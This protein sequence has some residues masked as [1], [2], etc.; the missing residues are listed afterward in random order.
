MSGP[1]LKPC[2][3][4]GGTLDPVDFGAQ[5]PGD[6]CVLS[7]LYVFD[8]SFDDWN[9]RAP[10]DYAALPEVQA[11]IAAAEARALDS[12]TT[13]HTVIA[14]IRAATVGSKPMLS[15]LARAL[16]AWRDEAVA[17]ERE[18]CLE[19]INE[20][21]QDDILQ[22]ASAWNDDEVRAWNN[23]GLDHLIAVADA[24]RKRGEGQP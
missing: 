14:D 5:H 11:L 19:I 13:L 6:D 1:E 4:C 23:G 20:Y 21:G 10:V 12:V 16:V 7:Q 15:D 8:T 18:A 24:I 22:P 9:T 2:P 17:K 3:F